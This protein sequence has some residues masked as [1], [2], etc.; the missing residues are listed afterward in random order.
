MVLVDN[1]DSRSLLSLFDFYGKDISKIDFETKVVGTTFREN[2]QSILKYLSEVNPK[3][4]V[5]EFER[6]IDNK[7]DR[8]AVKVIVGILT[9][10]KR[11]HIG[12]IPRQITDFWSYV[13]D[14]GDYRVSV[15][16][17]SIYGGSVRMEN[18]GIK[19]LYNIVG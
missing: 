12:Y 5:L 17:V 14:R 8:N 13:L 18:Y 9:S 1:Y 3:I 19:F 2:G 15:K 6:E 10:S 4:I 11:Y 7:Y 16:D